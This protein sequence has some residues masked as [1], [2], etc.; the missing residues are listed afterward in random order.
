MKSAASLGRDERLRLF[1]GL[2]I[3]HEA[4]ELLAE[5]A[6]RELDDRSGA[7]LLLVEHLHVTLAFLGG[8]PAGELE[9]LREALHSAARGLSRPLL[10][11][12]RYRETDRVAMLVLDDFEGRAA[13]VQARLAAELERLGVY[14]PEAR[15]WLAH[16]T[17]A[18]CRG[19][20]R[21]K[22][23]LP[24]IPAFSPSEAALY[25]STLRPSGASYEILDAA[26]LDE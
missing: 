26:C 4:A 19:R 17:V 5:W 1:F 22:P 8:R 20:L 13:L 6:S 11:P 21:A 9:S 24:D 10:S 23:K 3:P 2:P 12:A 15:S 18:R 7:R 25:H 14:R 16:V